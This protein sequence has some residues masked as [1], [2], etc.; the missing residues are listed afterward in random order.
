MIFDNKTFKNKE[1]F[2]MKAYRGIHM[3]GL[4]AG[5]SSLKYLPDIS[6]WN[7]EYISEIGILFKGC[8]FLVK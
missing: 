2:K 6:K 5:Y 7:M 4:F 3:Q 1:E 8:T